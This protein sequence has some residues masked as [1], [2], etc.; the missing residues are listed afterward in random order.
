MEAFWNDLATCKQAG[1]LDKTKTGA[2]VRATF[3]KRG[4]HVVPAELDPPSAEWGGVFDALA[5]ECGFA[6]KIDEGFA[7]VREFARTFGT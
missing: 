3:A 7:V 2:A 4:T 6:M 5:K 1:K